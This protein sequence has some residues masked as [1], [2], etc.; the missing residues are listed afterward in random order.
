MKNK[1]RK[2]IFDIE[3][4]GFLEDGLDYTSVPFKLKPSYK[5]WCIV[6][7]DIETEEVFSF[8]LEDCTKEA[9]AEVLE[10]CQEIAGHNIVWFD[11]P[12]LKLLG[13]I[14]YKIAY[15]G[16]SSILNDNACLITDTLLWSKILDPDRYGGHSLAS[17]GKRFG[18]YKGDFHEFEAYSQEMLDYCIQD[19]KVNALLYKQIQRDKRI[20][21][22]DKAMQM[23]IK[24]ADIIFRQSLFG[25]DFDSE[26]AQKCLIELDQKLL[27]TKEKV[28]PLLP[29]RKLNQGELKNFTAPKNQFKKDGSVSA[30][31]EKF[32]AKVGATIE[33]DVGSF[34]MLYKGKTYELPIR[35]PLETHTESDIDDLDNLKKYLIDMGWNPS[36]YKER[37]LTKNTD[38]SKKTPE[39]LEETIKRYVTQTF[40][41]YFHK[42]RCELLGC[43]ENEYALTRRLQTLGREGKS[44]FVP[45]GPK[46][47]V[48]V[49]KTLCPNLE[50]LGEKADFVQSVVHYLTYK[51]R[52]NMIAGGGFEYDPTT[53]EE[54]ETGL[55]SNVREDGRI[56]TPADTLAAS[57]G[58]FRHKKVCNIPRVT[59]LYGEP[60]RSLFRPGY[61][62]WQLGFDFASL[63]AR[64]QGHFCMPYTNGPELADMLLQEKPNDIHSVTARKL[65]IS[66]SD[67][68]NMNYASLY[69]AS[70][71]K[72][73]K[74]LKVSEAKGKELYDSFWESVPALKE[75]KEKVEAH[76][77]KKGRTHI[78]GIDGRLLVTRSKHSLVNLCFQSAGAL[79]MKWS[80]VAIIK[81]YE[82]A[83]LLIDPLDDSLGKQGTFQ[84]IQQHDEAQAAVSKGL[85]DIKVFNTE[86]EAIAAKQPG[87]SAIGHT[88]SGKY[89]I[90]YRTKV[91]ECIEEGIKETEELLKTRVPMAFEWIAGSNYAQC[92]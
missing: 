74:M 81:Q 75:F 10:Q 68:K 23:E 57:T 44:L 1:N 29:P 91:I 58:R 50:E 90:G 43:A 20:G 59:S 64:I 30:L 32:C 77:E 45:T 27:E 84:M 48:G 66:R 36:E 55:L 53:D 72:L 88:P 22:Y 14:D 31:M 63:E 16:E 15:P 73:A 6:I 13:L 2:V 12:V 37:D 51:H 82:D 21:N 46:I 9:L 39:Q 76:W 38:K 67:A 35:E 78:Q 89:Y 92:H 8:S 7:R 54:P 65:G 26:K 33:G 3:T 47:A 69:G 24:M 28:S 42:E 40:R 25:F 19:T 5:L 79:F 61:G 70:P 52:R 17:W 56:G 60:L 18:E 34:T 83:G 71:K 86:E 41:G 87:C 49:D 80:N 62:M 11:L 4:N 85:L